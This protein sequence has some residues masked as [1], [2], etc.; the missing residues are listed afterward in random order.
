MSFHARQGTLDG[1]CGIYAIINSIELISRKKLVRDERAKLFVKLV[2]LLDDGRFIGEIVHEGIG[3][4]KL[5]E[6]FDVATRD[7]KA[8]SKKSLSRRVLCKEEPDS[9]D[10]FWE[11]L[12]QTVQKK[13]TVVLLGLGG[14]YDHW[15][16]VEK[17]TDKSIS[18]VDSLAL[19]QLRRKDCGLSGDECT[20]QLWPTQS[21]VFTLTSKKP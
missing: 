2:S 6:L 12:S 8:R 18:L 16:V 1:L 14:N 10:D 17:V 7:L 3:F 19:K 20:H 9:V 21:Y 11:I 5:G 15:T 4:R 13:D